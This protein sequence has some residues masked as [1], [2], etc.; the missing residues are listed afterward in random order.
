[1]SQVPPPVMP[2]QTPGRGEVTPA[3]VREVASRQRAIMLCILVYLIAVVCQFALPVTMRWVLGLGIFALG[4]VA[5]VFIFMLAIKLYSSGLGIVLGILTL[6]PVV[7]LI[8]L[9]IV[10]AK[11]TRLLKAHGIRVGLLG[12]NPGDIR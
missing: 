11:A 12:A 8:V 6:I 3:D 10:N 4:I 9:L 5:A 2:Y 7:G 1:M